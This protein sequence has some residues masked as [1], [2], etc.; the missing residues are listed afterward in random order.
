MGREKGNGANGNSMTG[1]CGMCSHWKVEDR[2]KSEKPL[3]QQLL[4]ACGIAI[5]AIAE[6]SAPAPKQT[7]ARFMESARIGNYPIRTKK[8]DRCGWLVPVR[9]DVDVQVP[10]G[11]TLFEFGYTPRVLNALHPQREQ[12]FTADGESI[13]FIG[14][15]EGVP[16]S[17]SITD[18]GQ[19]IPGLEE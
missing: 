5:S 8:F 13:I 4:G 11:Q 14:D 17:T 18:L 6:K 16:N 15:V 12:Y 2:K 1:R 9:K 7:R 19:Y 3:D 10:H